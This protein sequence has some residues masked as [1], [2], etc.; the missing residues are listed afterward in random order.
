M[1]IDVRFQQVF[2]SKVICLGLGPKLFYYKPKLI[3]FHSLDQQEILDLSDP[4]PKPSSVN[5]P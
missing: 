5:H 4:K 1:T 2:S 3:T